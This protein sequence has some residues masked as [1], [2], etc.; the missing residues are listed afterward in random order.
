MSGKFSKACNLQLEESTQTVRAADSSKLRVI[1]RIK[2]PLVLIT[3][4]HGIPIRIEHAVVVDGLSA[5]ILL[6]EPAKASNNIITNAAE[7]KITIP[8][9]KQTFTFDYFKG[10]G[11]V[12]HITRVPV[13]TLVLPGES[14]FWEVPEQ[15]SHLQHLQIQPRVQDVHWFEPAICQIQ[16]GKVCLK[17]VSWA[18]VT[19]KRGKGFGEL[20][21]V[22]KMKTSQ[23]KEAE[24]KAVMNTYPDQNQYKART[25]K[26]L[27]NQKHTDKVVLDPDNVLSQEFRD[28]FRRL[29]DEYSDVIRPEPGRYNGHYGYMNNRINFASRPAPNKKIY[30]QNLISEMKKKLG[31][32]MDQLLEWGVLTYPEHAGVR[33]E[34]LCPSMIVPK[35]DPDTWRL[36][37]DFSAL[38]KFIIN[39][40]GISPTI[41]EAKDFLARAK[42]VINLDLSNWFYQSGMDRQ[43]IQFLGTVHP[44]KGVLVYSCEPQGLRGSPE[45]SYE[46]L[47]RIYGDLLRDNKATRMADGIHIGAQTIEEAKETLKEVLNRARLCGLTFK[48]GKIEICPVKTVLFG[49]QLENGKWSPTVHTTSALASAPKPKTVKQMRSFLG[50]YKQFTSCVP[51]YGE[52]LTQL[53]ALTGSH[54]PSREII[55]WTKEQEEAFYKARDSTKDV[56]AYAIP[57]PTDKLFTFSDYSKDKKAVGGKLEFERTMEDGTVQRFLGGYYSMVVDAHKAMWWACEGEA[58][59][60]RLVLEHFSRYIRESKSPTTHFTDNQPV[61]AAFN[62]AKRGA[63]STNARVSTFLST[64]SSLPVEIRHKPGVEMHSSDFA[65]RHPQTCPDRTCALCVFAYEEQMVGDNCDLLKHITVEEVTSG[66]VNMPFTS[67]KA[68]LDVQNE[69]QVHIKLKYL[70]ESGQAPAKKGTKGDFH[71]LKLLYNLYSKGDLKVDKDGMVL[72]RQHGQDRSGW[73]TSIPYK[74][75]PGLCQALHLQFNHPSKSQL[76][77]LVSRYFYSPGFQTVIAQIS[78]DCAQCQSMKILPKVLKDFTTTPLNNFGEKFSKDIMMR[79]GQKFL[80]TVE[81]LSGFTWVDEIP[82]QTADTVR[83]KLLEQV[84]PVIPEQGALIR[85]DGGPCMKTL[86]AESNA[87]GNIWFKLKLKLEVGDAYNKNKNPVGENKIREVEKEFLRHSPDGGP[88]SRSDV[89]MVTKMLNSRIRHLGLASREIMLS[90]S[91]IANDMIDLRGKDLSASKTDSRQAQHT[92]QRGYQQRMG[93]KQVDQPKVKIG[94]LV[95]MRSSGD[96]NNVRSQ[97]IVQGLLPDLGKAIIRKSQAQLQ[98]KKYKLVLILARFK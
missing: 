91:L 70:I 92:V 62:R 48:P 35:I 76:T 11:P 63:F 87:K 66:E 49:W 34:F 14:Y 73:V 45:H 61:V 40:Q 29:L 72:V 44:Y 19:L 13:S 32:K 68:W 26:K 83:P 36:I 1:G 88:L 81:D 22:K 77:S 7:R 39:P 55:Q 58:L 27:L 67:K 21:L 95:F 37:T 33:V 38:N 46:K 41:Q 23:L 28:E 75:F 69:D 71:K 16:D 31:D 78:E 54:R 80:V 56:E 79:K 10:R 2:K 82:D 4:E 93:A 6:G 98:A 42:Y 47:T 84:V 51:R 57:K 74:L 43:D 86:E 17:N 60:V 50:A 53:E 24:V 5:D 18:P 12:S 8:F 25:D 59:A 65:S 85:A 96:K 3:K 97:F 15:F 30:A 64:V 52:L 89:I 9:Q 20:R 94:D 90:R